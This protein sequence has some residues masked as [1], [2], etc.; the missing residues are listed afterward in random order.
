MTPLLWAADMGNLEVIKFLLHSHVN[1]N[2]VD[3]NGLTPLLW[4]ADRGHVECVRELVHAGIKVDIADLNSYTALHRAANAG[5]ADIV[6]ALLK[7][8]PS[9]QKI[10]KV[11]QDNL[12]TLS[13]I[14]YCLF[15]FKWR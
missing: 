13:G 6:E 14:S 3:N 8:K 15:K 12:S 4:A 2:C 7:G 1:I 11:Q 9:I 10:D 5:R